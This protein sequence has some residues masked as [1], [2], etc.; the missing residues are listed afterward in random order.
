MGRD[1]RLYGR[2]KQ[3]VQR[4]QTQSSRLSFHHPSHHYALLCG[5]QTQIASIL[6]P[7]KTAKN[8]TGTASARSADFS[9]LQAEKVRAWPAC[10]SPAG[11]I[12]RCCGINSALHSTL[13]TYNR[14]R[15]PAER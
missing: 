10:L 4:D 15:F 9:P 8:K 11:E 7:P 12:A 3:R 5:G 13:N 14:Q 2:I 6:I 1:Q